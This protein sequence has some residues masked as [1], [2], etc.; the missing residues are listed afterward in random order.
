M[1]ATIFELLL[2]PCRMITQSRETD[3]TQRDDAR[4]V[5]AETFPFDCI[6][7]GI[8][9]ADCGTTVSFAGFGAGATA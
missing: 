9:A 5:A 2:A 3:R 6:A 7:R 8:I 1:D 4:R